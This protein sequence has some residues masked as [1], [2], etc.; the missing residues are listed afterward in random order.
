M[1]QSTGSLIKRTCGSNGC[2]KLGRNVG[3]DSQGRTRYGVLCWGCHKYNYHDKKNYC[4][5]CGFV[6]LH[7]VQLDI[8]HKDGNKRN[9]NKDNLWTVC[10]NCHRLKTHANQDWLTRYE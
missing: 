9:N 4:E 5:N 8:D 7:S 6:A 10:A 3:R 2:N 1:G